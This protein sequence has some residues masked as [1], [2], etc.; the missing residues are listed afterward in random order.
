[1]WLDEDDLE[2]L[3]SSAVLV[4]F[5]KAFAAVSMI[6]ERI[7]IANVLTPD[8][9]G[10]VS[11][12][13]AILTAT[14]TIALLGLQQGV[15]RYISRFD[16]DADIRGAWLTGL[17]VAGATS[18]LFAGALFVGI[19]SIVGVLFETDTSRTLLVLFILAIPLTV[20]MRVAIGA[21]RGFENTIYRT[22]ARDLLYTGLRLGLLA[23]LLLSNVG[24]MAAG[25]A[26][27]ASALVA[28]VAAHLLLRRLIP[29]WGSYSVHLREM[30]AF[31]APLM[32][33]TVLSMFLTRADTLMLSYFRPS[34]QVGLYNAAYPLAGAMTLVLSSFGFIYLPLASRL[35]ADDRYAE[36][37]AVY[38][39]TTKWIFI[40]TLPI[41]VTVVVFP[42]DV[43]AAT[44]G[45][46]Y[47][48]AALAL[49]VLSVGFFTGAMFGRNRETVSA[50]GDTPFLMVTNGLALTIN[51]LLNLLLIPAY[52]FVGAAV[53]SAISFI[54][55]NLV[56]FAVLKRRYD[57]TPLSSQSLRT[58]FL[59]PIPLFAVAIVVDQF[60]SLTIVTIPLFGLLLGFLALLTL[61]VCGG[62][63]PEDR[64]PL[65]L[66]ESQLGVSFPFAHEHIP[67][68]SEK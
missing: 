38:T 33:S 26:Y 65:E 24:I 9:Y 41:F 47:T 35:D 53:T 68:Q 2:M 63:Q 12:G 28:F 21:I 18:L 19:D 11:V 61:G 17:L 4:F 56:V 30:L 49:M 46:E 36:I 48:P 6:L 57:I 7:L 51:V 37:D 52:G 20:G 50:L 62:L 45:G 3:L 14:S 16:T 39:L 44:F 10:E 34:Y 64:V 66:V 55:L 27:L 31:S 8:A 40:I 13:L 23:A 1:M 67:R 22:Y 59:V 54:S 29:L 60:A 25:Y 32:L 5:G 15:P 43:L 58:F 42:G